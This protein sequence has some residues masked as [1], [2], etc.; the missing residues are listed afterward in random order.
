MKKWISVMLC[1]ALLAGIATIDTKDSKAT[2]AKTAG[3][4]AEEE[5]ASVETSTLETA[6]P[7]ATPLATVAPSTMPTTTPMVSAA[8]TQMPTFTGNLTVNAEDVFV[9]ADGTEENT[10]VI[11]GYNGSIEAT[12]IYVPAKLNEKTVT[13]ISGEVFANCYFLQN[14]VVKGDTEIQGTGTFFPEAKVEIWG[15]ANGKASAYAT[16]A[17]LT[18]HAID[19]PASLKG[20]KASNFKKATLSWD[21][22]EGAISYDISRKKG[23][24]EYNVITNVTTTTYADNKL[25]AGTK[26]TYKIAPVFMAANGEAIVGN[27]SV[28][29]AILLS[30]AKLKKVR[31][32]GIRG[33]IQVR[34]KRDKSVTGYQVYMKV[35]VKG[36]KTKFN[37]V[38]TIKKNKITGY[39][40]KM[41]VRGMRYSYRVRSYKK[42]KGKKVYSPFVKVTTKAR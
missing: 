28:K 17:G 6:A 19:G 33:G 39:R 8:P 20:K 13:A 4:V 32:K 24:K 11:T 42:V 14:L 21:A 15:I 37:R 12:T 3:N 38:K 31:A 25:K 41:L 10:C 35:H 7:T 2:V 26:Y 29:K 34:W 23:K 27:N 1:L 30:P 18:F 22:V 40:C 16:A 36:F 5:R 9:V